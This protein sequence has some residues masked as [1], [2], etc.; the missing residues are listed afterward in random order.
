MGNTVGSTNTNFCDFLTNKK[1]A[2]ILGLWSAD[3]Y[4]FTS[5]LGI[6]NTNVVLIEKFLNFFKKRFPTER[7]RLRVYYPTR[8]RCYPD[9]ELVRA[10]KIVREYLSEKATKIAYHLYV[11]SRPLVREFLKAKNKQASFEKPS[12]IRAYIA[13]RFDGDGSI[14]KGLR[15]DCRIV[16]TY[17]KDA[18]IDKELLLKIG[19]QRISIY[20]YKSANTFCLYVSRYDSDKFVKQVLPYSSKLQKLVF[21]PRRDLVS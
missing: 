10:V 11:N 6:S 9:K 15:K 4:H 12:V 21:V 3:K 8:Y 19:I 20:Y 17:K 18:E 5:S 2:Y 7:L 13:G 1:D 16:Y 14:D